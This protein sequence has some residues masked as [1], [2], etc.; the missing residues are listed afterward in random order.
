MS[1]QELV[2]AGFE[3]KV[4]L[5]EESGDTTDYYYYHLDLGVISFTSFDNDQIKIIGKDWIVYVNDSFDLKI[6]DIN[7]VN[8]VKIAV[9]ELLK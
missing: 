6:T 9:T 7:K 8:Q 3:K 5:K 2:E 1:E 4:I